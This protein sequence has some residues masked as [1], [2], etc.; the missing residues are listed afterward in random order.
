MIILIGSQKGGVG[1]STIS[2]NIAASLA[3]SGK[4]VMLVDSD[5][6]SNSNFWC[7]DRAANPKLSVINYVQKYDNLIPTLKD[8]KT[9]YEYIIVDCAGRHSKELRSAL[10]VADIFVMPVI[11]SQFDLDTVPTIVDAVKEIRESVNENIKF[12]AVLSKCPT[13]SKIDETER[14]VNFLEMYKDDFKLLSTRI[15]DRKAY[16][17]SISNGIGQSVH[18]LDNDKAIAEIESLIAEIL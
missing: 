17:D 12:F 3:N 7:E 11:P 18:D 16:R 14:S 1:K 4:D 6:Q 10:C 13:N 5:R 8:L 9:R 15:H 2:I